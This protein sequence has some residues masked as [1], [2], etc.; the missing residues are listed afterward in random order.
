MHTL[1]TKFSA[2][3][4]AERASTDGFCEVRIVVGAIMLTTV[5]VWCGADIS[6]R[7]RI[8]MIWNLR[9]FRT[10]LLDVASCLMWPAATALVSEEI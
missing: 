7:V 6:S 4:L 8:Y 5:S 3:W 10:W 1:V 2:K 9:K